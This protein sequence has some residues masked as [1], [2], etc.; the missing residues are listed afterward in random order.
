MLLGERAVYL[1]N[2]ALIDLAK[3]KGDPS[4]RRRFVSAVCYRIR[5][6]L[7]FQIEFLSPGLSHTRTSSAPYWPNGIRG[8]GN[9]L[10]VVELATGAQTPTHTRSLK[11]SF[12]AVGNRTNHAIQ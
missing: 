3:A 4:R 2:R 10:A 8:R 12:F 6:P 11:H 5:E 7:E 9:A 1:D